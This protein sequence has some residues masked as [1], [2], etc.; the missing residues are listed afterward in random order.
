MFYNLFC[1]SFGEMRGRFVIEK[2]MEEGS[3]RA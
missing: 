2:L 1:L 3:T